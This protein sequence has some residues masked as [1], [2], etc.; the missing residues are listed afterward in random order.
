MRLPQ[1]AAYDADA[2]REMAP[3][4]HEV[5]LPARAEIGLAGVIMLTFERTGS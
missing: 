5:P 4:D 1:G 3:H 2:K